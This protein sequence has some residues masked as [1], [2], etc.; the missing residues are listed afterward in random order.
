M[1]QASYLFLDTNILLHFR[2]IT[3]I[4]WHEIVPGDLIE[5]IITQGVI[6]DLDKHKST[7]HSEK[8]RSRARG[9]L[10][11]IEEWSK[12]SDGFEIRP[13]VKVR[14]RCELPTIDLSEANLDQSWSDD[15]LLALIKS[16][17]LGPGKPSVW[18]VSDDTGIRIKAQLLAIDS[19]SLNE[20]YR[21][22]SEVDP[23]ALENERLKQQV[24]KLSVQSVPNLAIEFSN[25]KDFIRFP[26]PTVPNQQ[27]LERDISEKMEALKEKHQ[28][29]PEDQFLGVALGLA[30]PSKQEI[31]QYNAALPKYISAYENYLRKSASIGIRRSLT[32]EFALQLR[33]KGRAPADDVDIRIHFPDGMSFLEEDEP[34]GWLSE[35][36]PPLPPRSEIQLAN[37]KLMVPFVLPEIPH[38]LDNI[39]LYPR[40]VGQV[41]NVSKVK[42]KRINSYEISCSVK[43]LKHGYSVSLGSLTFYVD[44]LQDVRSFE[45]DYLVNAANMPEDS[46]GKI[47]F[48]FVSAGLPNQQLKTTD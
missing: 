9:L 28:P 3:E 46:K 27:E 34:S 40:I 29:C 17:Q 37:D 42:I 18:I 13:K 21:L 10:K 7:N 6:R 36:K 41:P 44:R 48:A 39:N 33:N 2:P 38:L 25:G 47:R 1:S 4:P 16:F 8:I 5:L 30:A 35:P 45:A 19:L 14:I 24:L 26:I 23:I 31:E 32:Y 20:A 15:Y 43:R 12:E 11:E 22:P